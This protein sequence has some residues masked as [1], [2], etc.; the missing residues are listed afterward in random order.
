M[1]S[2]YSSAARSGSPDDTSNSD[3]RRKD[4]RLGIPTSLSPPPRLSADSESSPDRGSHSDSPPTSP[5]ASTLLVPKDPH[6]MS[7]F[8]DFYEYRDPPK[9]KHSGSAEHLGGSSRRSSSSESRPR[10][11]RRHSF[12]DPFESSH[13][14]LHVVERKGSRTPPYSR[15]MHGVRPPPPPPPPSSQRRSP[16]LHHRRGS[17]HFDD[18]PDLPPFV[19]LARTP[20]G[21]FDDRR[22]SA[23]ER[24][25]TPAGGRA[26]DNSIFS[27]VPTRPRPPPPPPP[28]SSSSRILST[29]SI[30]SS[31]SSANTPMASPRSV[32]S[33]SPSSVS[34]DAPLTLPRKKSRDSDNTSASS[35]MSSLEGG[36][37]KDYAKKLRAEVEAHLA[38]P[39]LARRAFGRGGGGWSRSNNG[40]VALASLTRTAALP[41]MLV[42]PGRA[43][44]AG[45]ADG[46]RTSPVGGQAQFP[47][48]RTD[49]EFP[50]DLR[51]SAHHLPPMRVVVSLPPPPVQHF[52]KFRTHTEYHDVIIEEPE[53]EDGGSAGK[54]VSD[55]QMAGEDDERWWYADVGGSSYRPDIRE[56]PSLEDEIHEIGA[57]AAGQSVDYVPR[58]KGRRLRQPKSSMIRSSSADSKTGRMSDI[59]RRNGSS[60]RTSTIPRSS[61]ASPTPRLRSLS[62]RLR[63]TSPSLRS[64]PNLDGGAGNDIVDVSGLSLGRRLSRSLPP[65]DS[66]SQDPNAQPGRQSPQAIER[67]RKLVMQIERVRRQRARSECWG[68]INEVVFATGAEGLKEAFHAEM[69]STSVFVTPKTLMLWRSFVSFYGIGVL[70]VCAF[71][72]PLSWKLSGDLAILSWFGLCIYFV[73]AT[74]QSVSFV[75]H[76][77]T[78]PL[79]APRTKIARLL[80]LSLYNFASTYQLIV[81]L[82]YWALA[83][84]SARAEIHSTAPTAEMPTDAPTATSFETQPQSG[85]YP[86]HMWSTMS[87]RHPKNAL[88]TFIAAN[89]GVGCI[90][91]WVE[92]GLGRMPVMAGH[93]WMPVVGMVGYWCW[94]LILVEIFKP[95]TLVKV[96]GD[97]NSF[98]LLN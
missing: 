91:M 71:I 40:P 58:Q 57:T 48:T 10:L 3:R 85:P 35:D 62:P 16:N 83:T 53:D 84:W 43:F 1:S 9:P 81:P 15:E 69:V 42:Q 89:W 68:G 2:A 90:A 22:H 11:G 73:N 20:R 82:C 55:E 27:P 29:G 36:K 87:F 41:P 97:G 32:R 65:L 56:R 25:R 5:N 86:L 33:R 60:S 8:D 14:R 54:V 46:G 23:P 38:K 78:V 4:L 49:S 67:E 18:D 34:E 30:H 12:E 24:S 80:Y 21:G 64:S 94:S 17:S 6:I 93:W 75:A 96:L 7:P 77:E 45:S 26:N 88:E 51:Y 37:P 52:A 98:F 59:L 74:I 47:S 79:I 63:P 95:T 72:G 44:G 66:E 76:G 50:S 70:V 31:S 39:N 92:L 28:S 19:T 13:R 61:S